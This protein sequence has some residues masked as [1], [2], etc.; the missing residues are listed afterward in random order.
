MMSLKA[1]LV[2]QFYLLGC[3]PTYSNTL[4]LIFFTS[5][6][7]HKHPLPK[8]IHSFFTGPRHI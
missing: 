4:W 6:A 3:M 2:Y 1:P 7:V 5:T 8:K